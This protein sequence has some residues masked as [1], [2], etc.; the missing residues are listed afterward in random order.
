MPATV[1]RLASALV[2]LHAL[3]AI[4][5]LIAISGG[6]FTTAD[7]ITSLKTIDERIA[8]AAVAVAASH[9]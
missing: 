9:R 1:Y 6:A 7:R 2:D 8:T 5:M 3:R 4:V